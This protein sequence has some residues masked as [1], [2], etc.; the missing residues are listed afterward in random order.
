MRWIYGIALIAVLGWGLEQV[1]VSPLE[2]GDV[3]P[4]YSS[5]RSDPLGAKALYESLASLP[6]LVVERM[7]KQRAALEGARETMF[8]L[9]V[10][11]V[12]FSSVKEKELE[13]FEKL[14]ENGGRLV[15]AFVPVRARIDHGDTRAIE[16]RW[17]LR[18][19]YRRGTEDDRSA[20]PRATALFFEAEEPW[21]P[22]GDHDA[23]ERDFGRGSIALVAD[24]FPLSNEGLR[25]ARDADFLASLAGPATKIVFR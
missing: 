18:F 14:V 19:R 6:G 23:V 24:S 10:D 22:M 20:M 5:L 13:Q 21:R 2:T 16:E 4:P 12:S 3:Y 25:E 9:G 1:V 15:I 17:K 7:Y 8:V 11:P